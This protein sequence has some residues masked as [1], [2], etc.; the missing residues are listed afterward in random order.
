MMLCVYTFLLS[1]FT[2]PTDS[3]DYIVHIHDDSDYVGYTVEVY[4]EMD[5]RHVI[6]IIGDNNIQTCILSEN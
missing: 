4:N 2:F 3:H 5:M 6:N 1:D